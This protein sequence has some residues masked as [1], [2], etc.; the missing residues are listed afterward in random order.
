M[1]LRAFLLLVLVM[2]VSCQTARRD[3]SFGKRLTYT[4]ADLQFP[5]F[6]IR[7]VACKEYHVP[8]TFF[9]SSKWTFDVIDGNGLTR[10]HFA[11]INGGLKETL[12]VFRVGDKQYF[13]EMHYTTSRQPLFSK[14][15]K[16]L[17]KSDQI[18]IWDER[19]ARSMNPTLYRRVRAMERVKQ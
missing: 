17:L 7:F 2:R 12:Q 19:S 3:T 4:D 15:Q 18:I 11:F 6:R 10:S 9:Y 1:L 8:G 13:A 5:D 14:R 16:R